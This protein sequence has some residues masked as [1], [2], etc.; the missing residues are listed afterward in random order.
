VSRVSTLRTLLEA[1]D[2]EPGEV[3]AVAAILALIADDSDALADDHYVP[4]HVTA[5]AFVVDKS[6]TRLLLIHHGKLRVWLQPGGHVDPGEDVLVAAIREVEE[7]TGIVAVPLDGGL[8]DVD[9]HA[10]P[11]NGGRPPHNHY[12]VRFL[13]EG[14]NEDFTDSDEVLGVRWVTFDDVAHFADE[15]SVL[16][17][18]AKLKAR[19]G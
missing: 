19:F 10:I 17:P 7:E 13:L 15:I 11:A 5:S 14:T 6:H 9:V 8:F 12:D 3:A 2:P 18:A 16:R 4:G 1:Y